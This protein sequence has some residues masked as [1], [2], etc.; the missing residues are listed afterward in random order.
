MGDVV[1]DYNPVSLA[2]KAAKS[3]HNVNAS[4][5]S[6]TNANV[7]ATATAETNDNNDNNDNNAS[8]GSDESGRGTWKVVGGEDKVGTATVEA[9]V[10][11]EEEE[12]E[13]WHWGVYWR[14]KVS[15]LT[16][17]R[18]TFYVKDFLAASHT[19]H[20]PI[21]INF[22]EMTEEQLWTPD[23]K[24][25]S[26]SSIPKSKKPEKM[27]LY[28]DDLVWRLINKLIGKLLET[29]TFSLLGTVAGS[30]L[31]QALHGG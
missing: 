22:M 31:N 29:N 9:E 16:C 8:D 25:N 14:L 5:T 30:G 4:N 12:E 2:I 18:L 6:A 15:R 11:K 27:G 10:K 24:W 13:E 7:T 23:P 3:T 19:D 21:V 28:L 26:D 1:L 20:K 17:R